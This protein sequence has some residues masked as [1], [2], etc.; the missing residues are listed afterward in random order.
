MTEKQKDLIYQAF[1]TVL[2]YA[3]TDDIAAMQATLD[4][5]SIRVN[6]PRL[7]LFVEAA[8]AIVASRA[9]VV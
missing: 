5:A 3:E 8:T 1:F 9:E 7:D 4:A 6:D 2:Q